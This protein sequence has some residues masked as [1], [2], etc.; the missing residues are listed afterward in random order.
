MKFGFILFYLL[1]WKLLIGVAWSAP[2]VDLFFLN[3]G[4]GKYAQVPQNLGGENTKSF[5]PTPN[6]PW[7]AT[8][9]SYAF[10]KLGAVEGIELR[11]NKSNFFIK[12]EDIFQSLEDI[13]TLSKNSPNPF[14]IYYYNGHG[15]GEG[16]GWNLFSIPGDFIGPVPSKDLELLSKHTARA[17]E[18]VDRLEKSE[19]PFLILFD[20]CYEGNE[21]NF[22][23]DILTDEAANN[24][25]DMLRILRHL[26]QFHTQ[27][28]VLFS[29]EPGKKVSAVAD[30]DTKFT[31]K[32][33]GPLARRILKALEQLPENEIDLSSLVKALTDHKNQSTSIPLDTV[34]QPAITHVNTP[35]P[36]IRFYRKEEAP[37]ILLRE[38]SG[39]TANLS[40]FDNPSVVTPS[41]PKPKEIKL[42]VSGSADDFIT[43]G[44]TYDFV[45]TP[46]NITN[47]DFDPK[48]SLDFIFE[49]GKIRGIVR[50]QVPRNHRISPG[51]YKTKNTSEAGDDW[52]FE[53]NMDGRGC[54]QSEGMIDIISIEKKNN[55]VISIAMNFEQICDNIGKAKGQLNINW[56]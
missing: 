9:L 42:L 6:G 49:H 20:N 24:L 18:I 2:P 4:I 47:F 40:N 56:Q 55:Q 27:Y 19:V 34:T 10:Q 16:V 35:L 33:V 7:S 30:P 31:D 1:I 22:T 36:D 39:N 44:S 46:D 50:L 37:K 15:V 26:N 54:S 25:N 29:T 32:S 3:I 38:G 41:S 53:L 5:T 14:I 43:E 13:I 8:R 23:N 52:R 51:I 17:S 21:S 45:L 28:P 11:D 48:D 12:R